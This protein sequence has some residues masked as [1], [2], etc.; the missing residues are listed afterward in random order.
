MRPFIPWYD[1]ESDSS[2]TRVSCDAK[3]TDSS[4]VSKWD[5]DK[6]YHKI[7]RYYSNCDSKYTNNVILLLFKTVGKKKMK[8]SLWINNTHTHTDTHLLHIITDE[9]LE[10]LVAFQMPPWWDVSAHVDK[11]ELKNLQSKVIKMWIKRIIMT[12]KKVK[13]S[14]KIKKHRKRKRK[15]VSGPFVNVAIALWNVILL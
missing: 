2:E 3:W 13:R 14:I 7:I 6:I 11:C 15:Y 12:K 5:W 8:F 4:Y 1:D 10:K 9:T